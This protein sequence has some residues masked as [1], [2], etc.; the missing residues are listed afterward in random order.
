MTGLSLLFAA[1]LASF[2]SELGQ[3]VASVEVKFVGVE[4][5]AASR[6]RW[7]GTPL[8]GTLR[9]RLHSSNTAENHPTFEK[10]F[11]LQAGSEEVIVECDPG[12]W[13]LEASVQGFWAEPAVITV[14]AGRPN[15]VV[16][17]L[18]PTSTVTGRLSGDRKEVKLAE[19]TAHFKG[20]PGVAAPQ[21]VPEGK[22]LC[23]VLS[24]T[25][26]CELPAGKLDLKFHAAGYI[27]HY[28]WGLLVTPQHPTQA[29]NLEFRHGA[30]IT[31]WVVAEQG[32]AENA[33]VRIRPGL[34]APASSADRARLSMMELSARVND[35]GF[36]QLAGVS[37][38]D[39]V[40]EVS[41]ESFAVTRATVRVHD[42]TTTEIANPPLLLR[43]PQKLEIFIEPPVSPG[44]EPWQMTLNQLDRSAN[45]IAVVAEN[46]V[47]DTGAWRHT[48]LPPGRYR[49]TVARE[50]SAWFVEEMV[51]EAD[52]PPIFVRMPV[53]EVRGRVSFGDDPLAAKLSFGGESGSISVTLFS[54]EEGRFTGHLPRPGPWDLDIV[55]PSPQL[56][57]TLEQVE[58]TPREGQ[59][60]AELDLRLP[61]TWLRGKVVDEFGHG[62]DG[63]QVTAQSMDEIAWPVRKKTEEGGQFTILGLP[64]GLATVIAENHVASENYASEGVEVSLREGVEPPE[65]LL[66]LK[67]QLKLKGRITGHGRP[68]PG[69]MIKAQG[70]PLFG[71]PLFPRTSD[72]AGRFEAG[73]PA[74][75]QAIL[76]NV[77]PP[78]FAL[79]MLRLPASSAGAEV[80]IAVQEAGGTLAVEWPPDLESVGGNAS[81]IFLLHEGAIEGLGYF[82]FWARFHGAN[83]EEK[84]RMTLPRM[85]PGEYAA[86]AVPV[87][88]VFTLLAD[89]GQAPCARGY[90]PADGE[91]VLR[92]G[93]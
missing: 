2:A 92:V 81:Q 48:Q 17:Q 65:I 51:I 68:V 9:A 61:K 64:L 47:P 60:F 46:L 72:A 12:V 77:A 24:D 70:V 63:A 74:G 52:P 3:P 76:L 42:L 59:S 50:N 23:S 14:E 16:I 58:V 36:F 4:D 8:P 43:F 86:C 10:S 84:Q 85:E 53:V 90:L 67:R 21:A 66:T 38:G 22:V 41:K 18:W 6:T 27:D 83:T 15:R 30:A 39:Y 80:E 89:A 71:L 49:L 19:F 79:R 11:V 35:R 31:G 40:I 93:F 56:E 34:T 25:W 5:A 44:G 45:T 57:R 13:S 54:D 26:Q 7:A 62:V 87:Q 73:V 20:T 28:L 88:Q 32:S 75:V 37:P 91:L 69:A 78:G 55:A 82:H 1:L 33:E 29:G